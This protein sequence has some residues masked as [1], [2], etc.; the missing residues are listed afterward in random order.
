[1]R[2]I[3]RL[4]SLF[5]E[6]LQD[7]AL[8]FDKV[9]LGLKRNPSLMAWDVAGAKAQA[10]EAAAEEAAA[11]LLAELDL[12]ER[13]LHVDNEQKGKKRNGKKKRRKRK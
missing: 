9:R 13:E 3:N 7:R 8:F 11:A 5:L 2:D 10:A 1:M 4:F 12:E 6:R